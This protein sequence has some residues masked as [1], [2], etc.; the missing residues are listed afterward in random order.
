[1]ETPKAQ[2]SALVQKQ[3]AFFATQQTKAI[4]FRLKQLS[5]LKQA[6]LKY[7]P[8]IEEALWKDLH[9]SKEEVYLTE[10]SIVLSEI[11]YHLKK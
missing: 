7:Q 3:K 4:D 6:I 5:L 2:I 8:E 11:N 1:M 9:K 10:I